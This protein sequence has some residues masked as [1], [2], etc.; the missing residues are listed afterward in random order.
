MIYT[1]FELLRGW[2]LIIR[3]S[4]VVFEA[5]SVMFDGIENIGVG[6]GGI[7]C[8]AL[9]FSKVTELRNIL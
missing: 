5:C 1:F 4:R 3:C 2:L 9:G 7:K 8:N 6:G